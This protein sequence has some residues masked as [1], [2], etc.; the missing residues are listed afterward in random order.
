M[1]RSADLVETLASCGH[2]QAKEA[3]LSGQ[4]DVSG[5]LVR[6]PDSSAAAGLGSEGRRE[7]IFRFLMELVTQL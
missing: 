3:N 5:G 6:A 4:E 7:R 2:F 1:G